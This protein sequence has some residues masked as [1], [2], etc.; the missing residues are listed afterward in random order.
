MEKKEKAKTTITKEGF[1]KGRVIRMIAFLMIIVLIMVYLNSVFCLRDD[2]DAEGTFGTFYDLSDSGTRLDG[3]YIGSSA[4]YRSFI[5]TEYYRLHGACIYDL[6]TAGQ[7][8][9]TI[10]NIVREAVKEQ[11]DMKIILIEIRPFTKGYWNGGEG[12]IRK[13]TDSMKYS[14]NWVDTINTSMY[15]GN[16]L[17]KGTF[18]SNKMYYF[19]R[20]LLYHNSWPH[21]TLS[22]FKPHE[23]TT[24]YMGYCLTYRGTKVTRIEGAQDYGGYEKIDSDTEKILRDLIKYCKTLDQKVVFVSSPYKCSPGAQAK[25]NYTKAI[26]EKNGMTVWDF[27]SGELRKDFNADYDHYYYEP[28]HMN[29]FGAE[30]YTKYLYKQIGSV[31]KL[32]D[33]R[34]DPDYKAWDKASKKFLRDKKKLVAKRMKESNSSA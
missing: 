8:L 18:N 32:E 19:F 15:W 24:D 30:A 29:V 21:M 10:K 9:F 22:E 27:N 3:V 14:K 1:T 2:N 28:V 31:V 17:G 33:H 6:A 16:K 11:P 4:T 7:P 5:P 34:G 23:K 12:S 26:L 20:Y 13:V 25:L